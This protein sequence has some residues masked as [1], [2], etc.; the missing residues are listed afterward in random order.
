LGGALLTAALALAWAGLEPSGAL[1]AWCGILALQ[2]LPY[3]AAVSCA[4]M[5]ER[6]LPGGG[7]VKVRDGA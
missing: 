1:W 5:G 6:L 2:A 3:A 4:A 7:E